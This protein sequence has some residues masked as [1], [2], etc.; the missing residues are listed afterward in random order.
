MNTLVTATGKRYECSF[1]SALEDLNVLYADIKATLVEAAPVFSDPEETKELHY[2]FTG[3]E[4]E[5][6][7]DEVGYMYTNLA[8]I[9][10]VKDDKNTVRVALQRPYQKPVF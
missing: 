1:F 10:N 3:V 9:Q 5:D 6:L 2:V 4:D 7:P 8:Y